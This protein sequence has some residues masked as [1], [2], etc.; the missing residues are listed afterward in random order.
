MELKKCSKCGKEK[1]LSEFHR[2][3]KS[4]DGVRKDCKECRNIK[5]ENKKKEWNNVNRSPKMCLVCGNYYIP[6][7]NRQ[8]YCEQC[9]IELAKER[10]RERY[11]DTK[12]LIGREHLIG[13]NANGYKNGI[14]LYHL[15]AKEENAKCERCGSIN[16]L[17]VHHKDKDRTNNDKGNLEVICKSCHQEEHLLRDTQGRFAGSK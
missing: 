16:N 2:D 14:G 9:Q 13:E 11:H 6:N 4:K 17:L 10:C 5:P 1:L 12:E 3:S 15:L 7:S 8:E